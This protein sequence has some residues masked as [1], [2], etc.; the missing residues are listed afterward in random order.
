[1]QYHK[2]SIGK[3][4]EVIVKEDDESIDGEEYY[5]TLGRIPP[6]I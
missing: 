1:V 3:N 5:S 6:L 4:E 2:E